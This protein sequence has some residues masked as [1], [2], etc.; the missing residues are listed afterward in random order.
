[1]RSYH[2][3]TYSTSASSTRP[4]DL[5]Q[6]FAPESENGTSQLLNDESQHPV[7]RVEST[8]IHAQRKLNYSAL[9]RAHQKREVPALDENDIEESFVRGAS[10]RPHKRRLELKDGA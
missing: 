5:S 2:R 4:I 6:T 3:A 1:M 8:A 9:K 10:L 7:E